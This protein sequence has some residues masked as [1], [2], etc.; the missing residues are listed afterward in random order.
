MLDVTPGGLKEVCSWYTSDALYDCAWSEENENYLAGSSGDGSVKLW[1][2]RH[3]D[4]PIRA[5]KEHASEVHSID[6][7]IHVRAIGF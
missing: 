2:M 3:K 5:W 6:W 1:D 4:R 7:N